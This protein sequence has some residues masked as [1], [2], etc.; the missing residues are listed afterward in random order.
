M[1]C[2][3]E[4]RSGVAEIVLEKT[5]RKSYACSVPCAQGKVIQIL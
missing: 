2:F 3:V 5:E 4:V 1:H